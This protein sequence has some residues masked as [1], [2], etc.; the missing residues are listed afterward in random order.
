MIFLLLTLFLI[1]NPYNPV[2]LP[3]AYSPA[4]IYFGQER[5]WWATC[6]YPT[7]LKEKNININGKSKTCAIFWLKSVSHEEKRR[8]QEYN[9]FP[10]SNA[11][12]HAVRTLAN[13]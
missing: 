5:G 7:V 8:E 6:K 1:F 2:F 9:D 12:P 10:V 11:F 13:R 3:P 4:L